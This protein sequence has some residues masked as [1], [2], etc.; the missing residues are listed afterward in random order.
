MYTMHCVLVHSEV[1]IQSVTH[2]II[3]QF[4]NTFNR[5]RVN[6][7]PTT[8]FLI[9]HSPNLFLANI[10]LTVSSTCLPIL[11]ISQK[12]N[13]RVCGLSCVWFLAL[14]TVFSKFIHVLPVSTLHY[15]LG[16]NY[17]LLSVQNTFVHSFTRHID[18]FLFLG[19]DNAAVHICVHM[20]ADIL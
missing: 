4:P 11:D 14:S 6:A 12:W 1:T 3:I 15:F 5:P 18:H 16:H 9:P 17:I 7:M 2:I 19:S 8:S 10:D 20:S 13:H